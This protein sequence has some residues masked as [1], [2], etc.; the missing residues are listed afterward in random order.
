MKNKF[1]KILTEA[2]LELEKIEPTT[3]LLLGLFGVYN[4]EPFRAIINPHWDDKDRI[5]GGLLISD[6][7]E[8]IGHADPI[9]SCG[10]QGKCG[11]A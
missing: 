10:P 6:N 7:G 8:I 5:N 4:S 2:G 3:N 1:I 9:G 11:E